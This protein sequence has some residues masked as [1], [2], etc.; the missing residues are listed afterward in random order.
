MGIPKGSY[1]T[2]TDACEGYYSVPLDAESNKLTQFVTPFGCYRY[3][4]NP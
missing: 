4:T 2:M 1:K 3:L